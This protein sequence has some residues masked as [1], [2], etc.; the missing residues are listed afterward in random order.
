MEMRLAIA[1][2]IYGA[3]AV[4]LLSVCERAAPASIA[5]EAVQ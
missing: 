3:V 5:V 1:L 2:L 4:F